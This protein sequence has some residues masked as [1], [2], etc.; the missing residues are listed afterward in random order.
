VVVGDNAQQGSTTFELRGDPRIAMSQ[1]DYQAWH[2]G[3]QRLIDLLS[4]SNLMLDQMTG[5]QTQLSSLE[6][7]IDGAEIPN[8]DAVKEQINT[9]DEQIDEFGN[10]MQR[11]PPQMSYR[12]YPR[13]SDE[14]GRLM[15]SVAGVQA[16]PT[17]A[18]MTVAAEFG[19]EVA[20]RRAELQGII[21]GAIR[22]LNQ[23]LGNLPAVVV[24]NR[25]LIP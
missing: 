1:T 10:K 14:I 18:Q 25:S 4:E 9:A 5:L 21:N 16:V 6:E 19:V 15:G 22:E 23:M 20:E 24:P 7:N 13:L 3:T 17:E 8:V 12:Q 11:P 2:D